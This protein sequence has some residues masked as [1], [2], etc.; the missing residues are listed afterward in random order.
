[1]TVGA[2]DG[3]IGTGG[4]T[5]VSILLFTSHFPSL[6]LPSGFFV[7]FPHVSSRYVVPP[8]YPLNS[9][10]FLRFNHP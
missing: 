6:A 2:V 4:F 7:V 3:Y 5:T 9:P 8:C 1:M 10:H